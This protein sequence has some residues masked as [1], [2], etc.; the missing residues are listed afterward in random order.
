MLESS[1]VVSDESNKKFLLTGLMAQF[2]VRCKSVVSDRGGVLVSSEDVDID[3]YKGAE[4]EFSNFILRPLFLDLGEDFG[5]APHVEPL[6][7]AATV[8]AYRRARYEIEI[9]DNSINSYAL[10]DA[11]HA[12]FALFE[13]QEHEVLSLIEVDDS[14]IP[15]S[16]VV[17]EKVLGEWYESTTGRPLDTYERNVTFLTSSLYGWNLD[18][19]VWDIVS[20]TM[21][22]DVLM[23]AML[24]VRE[25][26]RNYT[27]DHGDIREIIDSY[28]EVPET[29]SEAV[30]IEN[31]IHNLYK[32]LEAI[33]GGNLPK[34]TNK[35]VRNFAEIGIDLTQLVGYNYGSVHEEQAIN[36]L[37]RLRTSRDY[38]AAHG[39]IG[40]DR[41][42]TFYELLDYQQ[43][44]RFIVLEAVRCLGGV[45]IAAV[46]D[47]R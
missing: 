15:G 28:T 17:S 41:K 24:F 11:I 36:K 23:Y 34:D 33:H 40:G 4:R 3:D 31:A 18:E 42:T 27:F 8:A 20:G 21:N 9:L 30:K 5:D 29:I 32:A 22:H 19:V 2:M 6:G 1:A 39:R 25:A 35:I 26:I 10:T 38:K 46:V 7:G 13:I 16:R 44:V 37:D 45:H 43:L 14:K 12:A 47:H